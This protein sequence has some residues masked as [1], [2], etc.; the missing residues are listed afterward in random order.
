MV[1]GGMW[2]PDLCFPYLIDAAGP[3]VDSADKIVLMQGLRGV[4]EKGQKWP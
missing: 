4:L 3:E 2:L 1:L